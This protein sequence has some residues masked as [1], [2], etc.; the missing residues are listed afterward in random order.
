MLERK[1]APEFTVPSQVKLLS[2]EKVTL[3]NGINVTVING[4]L[5]VGW[6]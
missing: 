4:G 2:P 3:D 1:L 6:L 5:H